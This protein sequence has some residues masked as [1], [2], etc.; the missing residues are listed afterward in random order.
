MVRGHAGVPEHV[1]VFG[2]LAGDSGGTS[3]DLSADGRTVVGSSELASP[4]TVRATL[5]TEG[6]GLVSLQDW[7]SNQFGLELPGW[8][9]SSAV[10][11]SDDGLTIVGEDVSGKGWMIRLPAARPA[12]FNLDRFVDFL[13]L[14]DFL[15]CF[16]GNSVLPVS[17]ADL[18]HDGFTDFFDL[19]EFLDEF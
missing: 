12:D 15:D 11:V 14:A 4:H 5:Y 17:S 7:L 6:L 1:V 18:N 3:Q 19:I 8:T 2:T 9:L 10:G 16:E 13:D